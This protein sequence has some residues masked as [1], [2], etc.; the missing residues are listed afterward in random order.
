MHG[1]RRY[2]RIA[3]NH[4]VKTDSYRDPIFDFDELPSNHRGSH[5]KTAAYQPGSRGQSLDTTDYDQ[6]DNF[7][8]GDAPPK[9]AP[10]SANLLVANLKPVPQFEETDDDDIFNFDDGRPPMLRQHPQ[11]QPQQPQQPQPRM[12]R[13]TM[14]RRSQQRASSPASTLDGLDSV[15]SS[16]DAGSVFDS[17]ATSPVD[18]NFVMSPA[19]MAGQ[20][21]GVTDR[22]LYE[23][24][25]TNMLECYDPG[26]VDRV[27]QMLFQARDATDLLLAEMVE[28]Y[29]EEPGN[30]A[31]EPV[32]GAPS[33]VTVRYFPVSNNAAEDTNLTAEH[34]FNE[35]LLTRAA[36]LIPTS[37]QKIFHVDRNMT[38]KQFLNRVCLKFNLQHKMHMNPSEMCFKV[39]EAFLNGRSSQ[40]LAVIPDS[41]NFHLVVRNVQMRGPLG[42]LLVVRLERRKKTTLTTERRMVASEAARVTFRGPLD[43]RPGLGLGLRNEL[44]RL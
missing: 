27:P 14:N 1:Q 19:V 9:P 29:G 2:S 16:A 31:Y 13:S 17:F 33:L 3:N 39:E 6:F 24:R 12:L 42:A 41:L 25:I 32:L 11:Q 20:S 5:H 4:Y 26:K 44:E 38:T 40:R 35:M 8:A 10:P 23:A 34:H 18:D 7:M 21:H 30:G 28:K 37:I 36:M 15:L 43:T 22:E